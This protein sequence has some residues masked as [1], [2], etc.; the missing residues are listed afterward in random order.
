MGRRRHS[1]LSGRGKGN[2]CCTKR[3]YVFP[4]LTIPSDL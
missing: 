2:L 3:R 1:L 4:V